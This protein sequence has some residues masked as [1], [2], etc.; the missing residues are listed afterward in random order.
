[1][2]AF[3]KGNIVRD[4]YQ[5]LVLFLLR[6]REAFQGKEGSEELPKLSYASRG[7][8]LL[9][10][11]DDDDTDGGFYGG[12]DEVEDDDDDTDG[13]VRGGCDDGDDDDDDDHPE[14]SYASTG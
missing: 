8:P 2:L 3:A 10:D 12:C 6:I 14:L 7:K 5:K 4:E 13:G 1:M 9:D 11:D